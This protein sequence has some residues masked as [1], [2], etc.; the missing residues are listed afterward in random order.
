MVLTR[1]VAVKELPKGTVLM[2]T[3]NVLPTLC[4]VQVRAGERGFH[5][6]KVIQRLRV[7]WGL[8]SCWSSE[9]WKIHTGEDPHEGELIAVRRAERLRVALQLSGNV[10]E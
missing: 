1:L 5:I 2:L 9:Q 7:W 8:S 6:H 4:L 10:A 3:R